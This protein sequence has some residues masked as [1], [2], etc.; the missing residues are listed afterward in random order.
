MGTFAPTAQQVAIINAARAG[1]RFVVEAGAGTG[2]TTTLAQAAEAT[3]TR[4]LYLAYNKAIVLDAGG[5]FP[6]Y[7]TCSTAH[8]L[9][10]RAGGFAYS[11][12]IKSGAIQGWQL[13]KAVGVKRW[14][15]G[16]FKLSGPSVAS[17][18]RRTIKRWA[19]STDFDINWWHVPVPDN[20]R[21]DK[22]ASTALREYVLPYAKK[23]W[24]IAYR[25]GQ[26]LIRFD[27]DW[28]LKLF[29]MSMLPA[30]AAVGMTP[31]T[32]PQLPYGIVLF[33]ECQDADPVIRHVFENQLNS[34]LIAV[35][36]SQ[37]AIYA[38]R[39]AVNAIAAFREAGAQ[40]YPLTT[41]WRFGQTIADEANGWLD[42]LGA[43]IRL[44]GNPGLESRIEEFDR[45]LPHAVLCRTNAGVM[46]A[47]LRGVTAGRPTAMVGCGKEVTGLAGAL[48]KLY[49]GRPTDHAELVGFDTWTD[50]VNYAEGPDCD[51]ITLRMLVKLSAKY[52]PDEMARALGECTDEK[53]ASLIVSTAHK[54][55]G[56]QWQRVA[57]GGD[58][59]P[60]R[61]SSNE[62]DPD[63]IDR[64][65]LRLAYVAVT[66]AREVLDRGLL[67]T[68]MVMN[69]STGEL[70]SI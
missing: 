39:G 70:A 69:P 5:A 28:Y 10:Y 58:F 46:E 59:E 37:Q 65:A 49:D 24:G 14:Q 22:E 4:G 6:D 35:G 63:G 19:G 56:R 57:I 23:I 51:N 33:D 8:S 12:A 60:G 61:A 45:S 43:D 9:A 52:T 7:V 25:P 48:C 21:I 42:L 2:K 27:H 16:G 54:S 62:T 41:S 32:V 38:W 11:S 1:E 50:L 44:D 15:H 29:S 26:A 34:Q 17:I 66:R 13:A 47:V 64:P 3:G 68:D 67:S 18:A 36:D 55:K 53:N 30:Q 40:M 20:I 31:G